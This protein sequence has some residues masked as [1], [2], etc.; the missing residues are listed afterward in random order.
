MEG[1]LGRE[2]LHF[3]VRIETLNLKISFI[4]P[5]ILEL[6]SEDEGKAARALYCRFVCVYAHHVHVCARVPRFHLETR[7]VDGGDG[8]ELG[9]AALGGGVKA[10][11]LPA[12]LEEHFL[13]LQLPGKLL[14]QGLLPGS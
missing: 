2:I 11:G 12:H 6:F 4:S 8:V 10:L 1:R 3:E 5:D 9:D 13:F 7:G 14:L